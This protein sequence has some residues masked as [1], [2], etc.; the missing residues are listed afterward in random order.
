MSETNTVPTAVLLI[1]YGGQDTARASQGATIYA[2]AKRLT[3]HLGQ[4][5]IPCPLDHAE[6]AVL[7][8]IRQG[9]QAGAVKFVALPLFI[10]PAEYQD[11]AVGEAIVWASR[12]WPF[13]TFHVSPP[14]DWTTW[15]QIFVAQLE[16]HQGSR[17]QLSEVGIVL[18]GLGHEESNVRG[19]L[20]KL[21][22]LI[23]E[24]SN[25]KGLTLA[26]VGQARPSIETA[27]AQM[28]ATGLETIFLQPT[29]LFGEQNRVEIREIITNARDVECHLCATVDEGDLLLNYLAAQ[30]AKTLEDDTLL[31]VSWDDVRR[32]MAAL[33]ESHQPF[34]PTARQSGG[35][36]ASDDAQFDNLTKRINAILPPRYQDGVKVSAEAMTSAE[37]AYNADGTVAWD[38]MWGLDDPDSPFCELALAGGPPHRRTLLEPGLAADCLAESGKYAAVL[39]E[40]EQGIQLVTGLSTVPS[41]VPGW[42]GLQC[43]SGEMAI[44]LLRAIIVENVMVRREDAVLYL[45][46][47]PHFTLAGEIKNVVTVVAKTVHYWT[48]HSFYIEQQI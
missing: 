42:I 14:L 12:R 3:D 19:D 27:I 47:A 17:Q 8:G 9:I 2:L 46:A 31:P 33:A 20:A 32:E 7:G 10:S 15:T 16:R 13:L 30:Y 37:L 41:I 24:A 44:W 29:F 45:P 40:L 39:N 22:R 23:F 43:A 26:F 18:I 6:N 36:Q 35:P 1:G 48:E 34:P 28:L 25:T 5:V 21:G 4:A 38:A 11:N